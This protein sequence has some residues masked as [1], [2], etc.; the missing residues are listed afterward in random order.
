MSRCLEPPCVASRQD[1]EDLS[2]LSEAVI[3][4]ICRHIWSAKRAW[5][6]GLDTC[7]KFPPI[8]RRRQTQPLSCCVP[9][10][11]WA[12]VHCTSQADICRA[13]RWPT[14]NTIK[15]LQRPGWA[16]FLP[17][18]LFFPGLIQKNTW[19]TTCDNTYLKKIYII[20][21]F[22]MYVVC[23]GAYVSNII[24]SSYLM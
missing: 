20:L 3:A 23:N 24:H 18:D 13:L 12:L 1:A 6:P 4:I 11:S 14:P 15:I 8:H 10:A 19:L 22:K 5:D 9:S 21:K 2:G 16:G 7:P 17:W